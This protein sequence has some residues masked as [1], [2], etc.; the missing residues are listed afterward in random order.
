MPASVRT[1]SYVS[2][3]TGTLPTGTQPTDVVL[4]IA[5]GVASAPVLPSG[6]ASVHADSNRNTLIAKC[7]NPSSLLFTNAGAV[8]LISFIGAQYAAIT[9]T[10]AANA[11]GASGTFGAPAVA[12]ECVVEW[13]TGFAGVGTATVTS[14]QS[15]AIVHNTIPTS[16][17]GAI[18]VQRW[19]T[20]GALGWTAT[21]SLS[22]NSQGIVEIPDAPIVSSGSLPLL[23]V[24]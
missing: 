9:A 23:G 19:T 11:S 17:G 5:I 10:Q 3:N 2:G 4:A 15:F 24:G 8:A 1:F 16:E 7:I 21:Q 12:G 14:S 18:F 22:G 6:W 20:G 13:L